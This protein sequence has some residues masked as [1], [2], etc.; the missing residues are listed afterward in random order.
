M[1]S[2][3]DAKWHELA[4]EVM[5]GM[6]E[7]LVLLNKYIRSKMCL[8][9]R[10]VIQSPPAHPIRK[11]GHALLTYLTRPGIVLLPKHIRS[12]KRPPLPR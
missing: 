1:D 11:A 4:E 3:F 9:T 6:K 12:E 5:S 7:W 10:S 8:Q 2:D